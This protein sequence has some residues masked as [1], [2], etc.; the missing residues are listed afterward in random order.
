MTTWDIDALERDPGTGRV[1][2]VHWRA[3]R[4]VDGAQ[5]GTYGA[6]ELLP[7]STGL[8]APAFIPFEQLTKGRVIQWVI[9]ALAIS[10]NGEATPL[11]E[12]EDYLD[13][14]VA[15]QQSQPVVTGTPW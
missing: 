13:M 12:I 8:D 14:M 7:T 11:Q 2:V 9:E 15:D 5:A 10:V 1:S 3:S 4:D 6:V